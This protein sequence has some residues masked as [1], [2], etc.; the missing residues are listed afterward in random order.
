LPT[1]QKKRK[2]RNSFLLNIILVSSLN[3][4][5][6]LCL[7]SLHNFFFSILMHFSQQLQLLIW[8]KQHTIVV[9][10]PAGKTIV[11]TPEQV[12]RRKAFI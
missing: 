2:R 8:M 7:K 4:N 5:F 9:A 11:L 3:N 1:W 12:K 10:D 6:K